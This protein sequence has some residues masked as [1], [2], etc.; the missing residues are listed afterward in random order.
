VAPVLVIG[1]PVLAGLTI[2]LLADSF[3]VPRWLGFAILTLTILMP[4][5]GY[6]ARTGWK[7]FGLVAGA[8]V[9]FAVA[10]G[11][12]SIDRSV[13]IEFLPMG[14]HWLWHSV[15]AVAVHLLMLYIYRSDRREAGAAVDRREAVGALAGT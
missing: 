11:F 12:R 3:P 7:D 9:G 15:G 2:S 13:A 4:V 8:L 14:T 10:V 1:P 6:L 5:L